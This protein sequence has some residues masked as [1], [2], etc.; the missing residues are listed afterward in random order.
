MKR[1]IAVLLSAL[2]LSTAVMT[3][4]GQSSSSQSSAATEKTATSAA[5]SKSSGSESSKTDSSAE[6][7]SVAGGWNIDEDV[8]P[9]VTKEQNEEFRKSINSFDSLNME[10]VALLA[11]QVVKGTYSAFLCLDTTVADNPVTT[12]DIAVTYTDLYGKAK[13]TSI[14]EVHP[15]NVKTAESAGEALVDSWET[16]EITEGAVLEDSLKEALDSVMTKKYTP[17]TVLGTQVVSGTNYVLLVQE[18][19][20]GKPVNYVVELNVDSGGKAELVKEAV[21]DLNYYLSIYN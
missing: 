5:S 19:E 8:K 21:F 4:C 1:I 17:I 18:K 3:G 13:L 16:V 10:P 14:I 20:D 11:Q 9:V 12:W 2:V 7:S 15:D 6:E